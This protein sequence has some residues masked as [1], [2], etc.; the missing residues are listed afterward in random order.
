MER[1]LQD[2]VTPTRHEGSPLIV[3]AL[4]SHRQEAQ[5][6]RASEVFL[7]GSSQPDIEE[8][9]I[10]RKLYEQSMRTTQNGQNE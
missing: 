6:A 4:A 7:K 2:R 9:R 10:Y 1:S 5:A 3:R 8:D